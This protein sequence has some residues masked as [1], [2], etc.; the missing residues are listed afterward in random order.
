MD[1]SQVKTWYAAGNGKLVAVNPYEKPMLTG[2]AYEGVSNWS[3]FNQWANIPVNQPSCDESLKGEYGA[4]RFGEPVW[5][6]AKD[7]KPPYILWCNALKSD[8]VDFKSFDEFTGYYKTAF[9]IKF[10]TR[11]FLPLKEV[12]PQSN[13]G[14][15]M[16]YELLSALKRLVSAAK[17]HCATGSQLNMRVT[18]SIEIIQSLTHE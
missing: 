15:D 3:A 12:K 16:Q 13:E 10:E 17:P 1:I 5:Q 8:Y 6:F 14:N 7:T 18:E 9:D 4:D 11:L 2:S